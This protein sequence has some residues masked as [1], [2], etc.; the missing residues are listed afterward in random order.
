MFR[1]LIVT[2][3][4]HRSLSKHRCWVLQLKAHEVD[5]RKRGVLY[6][7]EDY[8]FEESEEPSDRMLLDEETGT[9]TLEDL[10]MPPGYNPFPTVPYG[11]KLVGALQEMKVRGVSGLDM[12]LL[13]RYRV[14]VSPP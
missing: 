13:V 10:T 6:T 14:G 5:L 11:L 7:E 9:E 4:R 12:C 1:V 8:V 2:Y 3:T